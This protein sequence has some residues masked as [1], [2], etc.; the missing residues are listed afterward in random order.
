MGRH[1]EILWYRKEAKS[2]TIEAR[3]NYDRT[4]REPGFGL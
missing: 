4:I 2:G 1:L 3:R